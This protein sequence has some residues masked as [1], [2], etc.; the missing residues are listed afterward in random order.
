VVLKGQAA[1]KEIDG[2]RACE[3][4]PVVTVKMIDRFIKSLV[5]FWRLD[6]YGGTAKYHCAKLLKGVDE[7]GRLWERASDYHRAAG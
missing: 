5:R 2:I 4:D 6:F 3:D 1:Q 7:F